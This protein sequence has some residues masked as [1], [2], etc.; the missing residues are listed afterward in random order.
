MFPVNSKFRRN[1]RYN[2]RKNKGTSQWALFHPYFLIRKELTT[3]HSKQDP[4]WVCSGH[5]SIK[6]R[7]GDWIINFTYKVQSYA[8][9]RVL[10]QKKTSANILWDEQFQ[11]KEAWGKINY[12][13]CKKPKSIF[14]TIAVIDAIEDTSAGSLQE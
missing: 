2:K 4:L 6:A 9:V 14:S 13:L 11:Q 3:Y 8:A 5:S 10:M 12:I 1:D 7:E